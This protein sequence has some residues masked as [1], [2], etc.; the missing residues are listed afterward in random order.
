MLKIV[1]VMVG[2]VVA[3]LVLWWVLGKWGWPHH[4]DY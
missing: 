2:L 3:W 1:A 4:S